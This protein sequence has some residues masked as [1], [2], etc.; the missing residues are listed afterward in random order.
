MTL[1]LD[2]ISYLVYCLN[3][4]GYNCDT[5]GL[6]RKSPDPVFRNFENKGDE[7]YVTVIAMVI[8]VLPRMGWKVWRGSALFTSPPPLLFPGHPSPVVLYF[9][10]NL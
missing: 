1:I 9:Q 6:I 3:L 5:P 4:L 7:S 8:G 2:A 10:H